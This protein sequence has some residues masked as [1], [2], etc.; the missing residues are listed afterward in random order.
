MKFIEMIRQCSELNLIAQGSSTKS[1]ESTDGHDDGNYDDVFEQEMELDD[2]IV[3][4]GGHWDQMETE[5]TEANAPVDAEAGLKHINLLQET[6]KYGQVLR[7]EFR[8]D[9]RKEVKKALEE[10]FSVWAYEDPKKSI[11][12][13]LLEPSGRAPVAE[14]LNS[15]ILGT[16][17]MPYSR[18]YKGTHQR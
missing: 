12:A 1:T 2:Q 7:S 3:G 13:H 9:G 10:T 14:E 5:D 6:I 17:H 18:Y 4:G 15:A 8:D 11:V 16:L